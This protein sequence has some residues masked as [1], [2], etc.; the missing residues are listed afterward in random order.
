MSRRGFTFLEL[1]TALAIFAVLA[2]TIQMTVQT[3]ITTFNKGKEGGGARYLAHR[4]L[5]LVAREVRALEPL[6]FPE[7][8]FKGE[9]GRMT[10]AARIRTSGEGWE[11]GHQMGWAAFGLGPDSHSQGRAFVWERHLL[12]GDTL[13]GGE[14]LTLVSPVESLSFLYGGYEE[15]EEE[16]AEGDKKELVWSEEWEKDTL[17]IGIEVY[18]TIRDPE[19]GEPV[20]LARTLYLPTGGQPLASELVPL[21]PPAQPGGTAGTLPGGTEGPGVEE[22]LPDV[23]GPPEGMIDEPPDWLPEELLPEE[24]DEF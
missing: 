15:N 3:G 17:P 1:I 7:A 11:T 16:A 14:A 18:L 13:P 8:E 2:A 12:S 19:A 10:Y 22:P 23:G 5:D 6:S 4:A 9:P 24:P 21:I 20:E